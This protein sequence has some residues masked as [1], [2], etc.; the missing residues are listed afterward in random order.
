[1]GRVAFVFAGQGDQYPGMGRELAETFASAR[2]V[3]DRCDRIRPGTSAQCFSGTEE[4]LK[5]TENT[6]P[7]LFAMELA[8]VSVLRE[9]GI[10]PNAVAGFSLGEVAACT[11][12][13]LVDLETGFSLVCCRGALMQE[14]ADRQDTGMAA[15]V[16][17]AP[18]QV[19][20]VCRQFVQVYPVNYN[21]PG[22]I[23]VAG[24]SDQMTEFAAAV[25]GAGGRALPLKVKAAFHS[26]FMSE[27]ARDFRKELEKISFAPGDVP[28]Y[29]NVTA[30]P[31]GEAVDLLSRQ[32]DSPVR[33][34]DTIRHMIALGIDTFIEIGPGRTLTNMIRK[35]D[36]SVACYSMAQWQEWMETMS[37]NES[38]NEECVC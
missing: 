1:M 3:F 35:I 20:A 23:T 12:A 7:C 32:M 15:V 24:R 36:S 27:A 22:Q 11:A 8:A 10:R 16:K 28:L 38:C 29:S 14:A 4:E 9:Q 19:E 25:K 26:P 34:E 37:C 21:C 2:E 30:R 5:E 18:E 6:Q 31:Y 33:W 17:L 13:G